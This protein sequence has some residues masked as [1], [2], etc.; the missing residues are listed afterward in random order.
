MKSFA[1]LLFLAC[2]LARAASPILH[3][4]FE[5]GES[6]W[7]TMGGAAT[8]RVTHDPANVKTGKSALE[9]EYTAEPKRFG[10]ALLPL[11]DVSIANM[12]TIRFWLKTDSA[13][14][15][16]VILSEKAPGGGRYSAIAWSPKERWQQ[17]ELTPADFSLT[18][19]AND[20]KD[21][22]G[23]LDLD[24]LQAVGIVDVSQMFSAAQPNPD[25]P[26]AIDPHTGKHTMSIDDFDVLDTASVGKTLAKLDGVVIDDFPRQYVDWLTLGGA[27]LSLDASGKPLAEHAMKAV[28]QQVEE[29]YIVFVHKLGALDLSEA[30]R[31]AFDVASEKPAQLV[32]S[33]EERS[34]G[35]RQ[36]PRYSVDIEVP[37]GGK[38]DRR[39]VA[40]GAFQ[41]DQ[42][43]PTDP[44]GKL[45]L[46]KIKTISILDV[47][48]A[49]T[50][51]S[52]KNTLWIGNIHAVTRP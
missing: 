25:F 1:V 8:L 10:V 6:G 44:N 9:F 3:Q 20:P 7:V 18:D 41:P 26:I 45:D 24:R 13:T 49:Y 38:S 52:A 29:Q 21:S 32:I 17:I 15:I 43:G 36:G 28:Y 19:E 34:P 12:K 37:G 31:L 11:T 47:T 4:D 23:K 42:N 51:E 14:A 22:N 39:E 46:D 35:K 33:F 5:N 50:H 27:D 30:N 40:L 2:N 48:A 16:A